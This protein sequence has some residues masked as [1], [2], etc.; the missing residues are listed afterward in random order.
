MEQD[1]GQDSR[2]VMRDDMNGIRNEV[3]D[4]RQR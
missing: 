4:G 2:L 1:I 3:T